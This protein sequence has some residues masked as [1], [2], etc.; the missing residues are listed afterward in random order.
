VDNGRAEK[1]MSGPDFVQRAR[2]EDNHSYPQNHQR[3]AKFFMLLMIFLVPAT[4]AFA[5]TSTP[6]SDIFSN[7]GENVVNVALAEHEQ[8]STAGPPSGSVKSGSS[9]L[10]NG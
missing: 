10:Y 9:K 7:C 1:G 8:S 3:F 5:M 4:S 6:A 2:L